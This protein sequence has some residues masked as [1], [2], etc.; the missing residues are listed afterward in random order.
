MQEICRHLFPQKTSCLFATF[1]SQ[2][3]GLPFWESPV[4]Q[5]HRKLL[6]SRYLIINLDRNIRLVRNDAHTVFRVSFHQSRQYDA[7][8]KGVDI[9]LKNEKHYGAACLQKEYIGDF[10]TKKRVA[11][12]KFARMDTVT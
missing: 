3:T 2:K 12:T 4:S 1:Y 6:L 9:L 8:I 10:R 5:C 11:N 7:G